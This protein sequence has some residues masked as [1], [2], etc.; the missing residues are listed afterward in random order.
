MDDVSLWP[1]VARSVTILAEAPPSRE[2][3][4]MIQDQVL[5]FRDLIAPIEREAF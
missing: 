1:F 4:R 3:S 5:T 2:T